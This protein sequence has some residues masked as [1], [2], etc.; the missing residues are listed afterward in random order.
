MTDEMVGRVIRPAE[1]Y[2]GKQ[3][4]SYGAG[5]SAETVGARARG[6]KRASYGQLTLSAAAIAIGVALITIGAG[7]VAMGLLGS[8]EWSLVQ[9]GERFPMTGGAVGLVLFA[10]GAFLIH[11]T[12]YTIV[13]H[14]RPPR[15]FAKRHA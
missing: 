2:E 10:L 6:K 8:T 3:G 15:R 1:N 7:L 14:P 4:A 9:L 12:R 13:K 11:E 5:V